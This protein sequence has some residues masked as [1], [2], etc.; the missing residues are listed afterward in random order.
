M[1]INKHENATK[2]NKLCDYGESGYYL[3]KDGWVTSCGNKYNYHTKRYETPLATG[4]KEFMEPNLIEAFDLN[5]LWI[6]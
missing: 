3:Q 4:Y 2:D 5:K 1:S 6:I